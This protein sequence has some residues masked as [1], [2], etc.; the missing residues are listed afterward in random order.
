MPTL[1]I[2]TPG[3][4][5]LLVLSKLKMHGSEII[6]KFLLSPALIP[7][8]ASFPPNPL[9]P[10]ELSPVVH[11]IPPLLYRKNTND[12]NSLVASM[13]WKVLTYININRQVEY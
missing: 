8:I 1:N 7:A 13:H 4:P 2:H 9:T 3:V 11:C 10:P 6:A 12:S 5:I